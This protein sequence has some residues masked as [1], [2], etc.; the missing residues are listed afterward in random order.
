ML[1]LRLLLIAR[2]THEP[3]PAEAE[4]VEPPEWDPPLTSLASSFDDAPWRDLNEN[5]SEAWAAACLLA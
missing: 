1:R 3:E 4:P 2:S 5:E